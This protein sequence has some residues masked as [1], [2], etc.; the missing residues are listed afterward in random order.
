[1]VLSLNS[2]VSLFFDDL[3]SDFAKDRRFNT[4]FGS[5]RDPLALV[6]RAN[7][8]RADKDD[9]QHKKHRRNEKDSFL[10]RVH[11]TPEDRLDQTNIAQTSL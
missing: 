8:K 3:G 2:D 6:E 10:K 1:M 9:K 4:L 11:N 5:N 7:G